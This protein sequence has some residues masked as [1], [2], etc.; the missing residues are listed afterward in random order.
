MSR[1]NEAKKC[2]SRKWYP[3]MQI[4]IS[5]HLKNKYSLHHY[6]KQTLKIPPKKNLIENLVG[7]W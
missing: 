1:D 3:Q 5:L 6:L 4:V 2:I 7:F